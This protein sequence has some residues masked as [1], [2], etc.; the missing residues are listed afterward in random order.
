MLIGDYSIIKLVLVK[1][2]FLCNFFMLGIANYTI[3][4]CKSY[5]RK[6]FN[7]ITLQMKHVKIVIVFLHILL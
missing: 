5:I 1:M 4:E 3:F 6:P 7:C 2:S